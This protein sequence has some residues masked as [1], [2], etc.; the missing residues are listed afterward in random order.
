MSENAVVRARVSEEVKQEA[1]EVLAEMGLTVS[2]V[3]R[4]TLK[5]VARDRKLPFDP[6]PNAETAEV[7]R[8]SRRGEDVHAHKDMDALFQKLGM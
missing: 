2:D 8:K 1:T 5:R 6:T 4:M 3:V 7:L